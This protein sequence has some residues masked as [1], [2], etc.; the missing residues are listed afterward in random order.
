MQNQRDIIKRKIFSSIFKAQTF[1][2]NRQDQD[3]FWR[4]YFLPPGS[5]EAWTSACVG[6]SLASAYNRL[7]FTSALKRAVKA[8][9]SIRGPKGW[10]YNR[11]T[12][13]DADST[14]W[15][16]R[17]IAKMDNHFGAEAAAILK[18]YLTTGGAARTFLDTNRFGSWALEHADVTPVVGMALIAVEAESSIIKRVRQACLDTWKVNGLWPSFWWSTDSY[19]LARNLEFLSES[20]GI[21]NYVS[22]STLERLISLEKPCSPFEASNNLM[23]AIILDKKLTDFSAHQ[24]LVLLEWQ[25]NDGSW[26]SSRVLRVPD[27]SEHIS[28]NCTTYEDSMRL[29]STS[30]AAHALDLYLLA[31]TKQYV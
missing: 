11:K 21:P 3:G 18:Q 29:M 4:D 2:L 16:L 25:L 17:F 13:T 6:W 9:N 8:V 15:T 28:D 31:E 26:P 19:S 27:Q 24:V 7:N 23:S 12:A 14:A 30:M 20:G 10:G 5:S 22:K 1:L